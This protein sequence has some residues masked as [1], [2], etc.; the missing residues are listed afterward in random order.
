MVCTIDSLLSPLHEGVWE[1]VISKNSVEQPDEGWKRSM[2]NLPTPGTIASYRK[3]QY[4]A[5]ETAEEWRVH[6]DRYDPKKHPLMHLIDDAPLL[7]MILDTFLTLISESRGK[8]S[9]PKMILRYQETAWKKVLIGGFILVIIGI[10]FFINPDIWF[11]RITQI[12]I[13]F[14][15]I[16]SGAFILYS[17]FSEK[18]NGRPWNSALVLGVLILGT[19]AILFFMP[20]VFWDLF[21]LSLLGFWMFSTA[22]VLI[23]RAFGGRSAI[24]EGFYSRI[25]IGLISLILAIWIFIEPAGVLMLFMVILGS[26]LVILG[27]TLISVSIRLQRRMTLNLHQNP[28]NLF[29]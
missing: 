5:H 20:Q 1:V 4:H 29:V 3:G 17:G 11:F 6:L 10:T 28:G 13:P 18:K 26:I 21:L 24:P 8:N 9:N 16:I 2:I 25:L 7:L 23:I 27:I 22:I 15:V 12:I 14:L 19:G